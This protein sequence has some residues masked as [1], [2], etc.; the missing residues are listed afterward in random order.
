MRRTTSIRMIN[1]SLIYD[2]L[3]YFVSFFLV[4][5]YAYSLSEASAYTERYRTKSGTNIVDC[6][7]KSRPVSFYPWHRETFVTFLKKERERKRE[8]TIHVLTWEV[9]RMATENEET[10]DLFYISNFMKWREPRQS[11]HVLFVVMSLA[12]DE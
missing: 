6:R 1:L 5:R 10:V 11:Y 4:Y 8:G 9:L 3:S 2:S 7:S 12:N